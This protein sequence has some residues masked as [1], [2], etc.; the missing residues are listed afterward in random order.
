MIWHAR[1]IFS[2]TEAI[3]SAQYAGQVR[4]KN[5]NGKLGILMQLKCFLNNEQV[6]IM[7]I[8]S[9]SEKGW[10]SVAILLCLQRI[11]VTEKEKHLHFYCIQTSFD[12]HR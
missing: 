5:I 6:I 2:F 8:N 7:P 9:A 1:Q 11:E 4:V 10:N 12:I 3:F